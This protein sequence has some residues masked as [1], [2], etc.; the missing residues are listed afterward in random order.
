MTKLTR[1]CFKATSHGDYSRQSESCLSGQD[2]CDVR[3][4]P[5]LFL[6][7]ARRGLRPLGLIALF[8]RCQSSF[9]RVVMCLFR[10]LAGAVLLLFGSEGE[11]ALAQLMEASRERVARA[12]YG[13]PLALR[14]IL[15]SIKAVQADPEALCDIVDCTDLEKEA[16]PA[17]AARF[18]ESGTE[19]R[20]LSVLLSEGRELLV[21][22]TDTI[23]RAAASETNCTL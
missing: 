2:V 21:T 17:A 8:F 3:L 20:H 19:L 6:R 16:L 14:L 9:L 23:T 10:F 18:V 15:D 7:V 13:T 5:S 11:V 4:S 22:S 1:C 12:L